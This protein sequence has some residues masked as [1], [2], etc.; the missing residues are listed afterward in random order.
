MV[1]GVS[2]CVDAGR[3][4]VELDSSGRELCLKELCWRVNKEELIEKES[5]S[6]RRRQ[7]ELGHFPGHVNY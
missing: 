5:Q 1:S 7:F 2:V 3:A 4:A 6:P